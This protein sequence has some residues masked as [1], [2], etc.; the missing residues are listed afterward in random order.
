[1]LPYDTKTGYTI[2]DFNF[3]NDLDAIISAKYAEALKNTFP[4]VDLSRLFQSVVALREN[5][6]A[7]FWQLLFYATPARR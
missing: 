1:M 6:R 3:Y 4:T 5:P 2:L 7:D